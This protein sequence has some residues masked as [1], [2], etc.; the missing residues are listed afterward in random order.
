MTCSTIQ[1]SLPIMV[2]PLDVRTRIDSERR[3]LSIAGAA[4]V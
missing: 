3:E 1:D 2:L 4:V